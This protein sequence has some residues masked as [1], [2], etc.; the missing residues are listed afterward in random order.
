M[1][2]YQDFQK[3]TQ[4]MTYI[5]NRFTG[6]RLTRIRLMKLLWAADRYHVRKYGRL[7]TNPNYVAMKLGPVHSTAL[8]IAD[9][10]GYGEPYDSYARSYLRKSQH[11][12][13][14]I[15]GPDTNKLSKSDIEA[16]EF[17]LNHFAAVDR[18]ELSKLTHDYPEWAKHEK[19]AKVTSVAIDPLDFFEDPDPG[20]VQNDPF[21]L[22][23]G[24]LEMSK[25]RFTRSQSITKVLQ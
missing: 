23:S 5:A 16:L 15:Q 1:A 3:V 8:N 24:H 19:W 4:A 12:N 17:G 18:W 22:D 14:S 2:N 7:V 13:H 25:E 11:E 9:E 21:A 10:A 20:V 6:K